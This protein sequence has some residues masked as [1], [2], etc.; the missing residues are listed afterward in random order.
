MKSRYQIRDYRETDYSSIEKLWKE[1]GLAQPERKDNA[2]VIRQCNALGG[3]LLVME[4]RETGL[5]IGSSWMTWDG[6]RVYLHHFG[7]LPTLQHRGFGTE[8]AQASLDWIRST[9]R[10]VKIE[11]HKDNKAARQLYRKLGFFVFNDYDICMIREFNK[12]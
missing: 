1:T 5:I 3:R 12:E 8:L 6:R 9:G 4:D 11:V 2:E 7:I 10:Q